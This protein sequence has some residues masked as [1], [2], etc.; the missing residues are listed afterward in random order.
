ML[1]TFQGLSSHRWVN[2]HPIGQHRYRKRLVLK[3]VLLAS[4]TGGTRVMTWWEYDG[5]WDRAM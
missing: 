4:T 3:K 1:A 2:G 5:T